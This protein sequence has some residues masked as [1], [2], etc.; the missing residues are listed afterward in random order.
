M[1]KTAVE[2]FLRLVD[3]EF[4]QQLTFFSIFDS[5]KVTGRV[6]TVEAHAFDASEYVWKFAKEAYG[7]NFEKVD[8][9]VTQ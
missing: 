1:L 5:F 3:V 7:S 4:G 8:F 2:A 9:F 6:I